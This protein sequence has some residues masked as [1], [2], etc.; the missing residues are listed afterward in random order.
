MMDMH[1]CN[2]RYYTKILFFL[3]PMVMMD[4]CM[5]IIAVL[6]QSNGNDGRISLPNVNATMINVTLCFIKQKILQRNRGQEH[7]HSLSSLSAVILYLYQ[8]TIHVQPILVDITT[9]Q[10]VRIAND[11]QVGFKV[12]FPPMV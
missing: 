7:D 3:S 2:P 8:N 6:S 1:H 10:L 9:T 4:V 12:S 11:F 5:C